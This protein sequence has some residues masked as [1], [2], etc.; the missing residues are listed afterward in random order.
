MQINLDRRITIQ[1]R[2]TTQ[3]ATYGTEVVTWTTLATVWAEIQD[4]MPSRDE[5]L[6]NDALEVSKRRTRIRIRWRND[7]DSSMR[8]LVTYPK[9]RTLQIIGGPADIGGRRNYMELMCEEID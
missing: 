3:D 1:Q 8:V 4:V 6:L 2:S 9:A 7:V 5:S